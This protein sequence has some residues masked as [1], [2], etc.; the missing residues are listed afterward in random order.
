MIPLTFSIL[1]AAACAFLIYVL[2]QFRR[3]FLSAR[4]GSAGK[5][6]L[7]VANPRH[8]GF[9]FELTG[10]SCSAYGGRL[11]K[12]EVVMRKEILTGV[13][14]GVVG[15]VAPFVIVLLLSSRWGH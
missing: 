9:E 7:A 12:D 2:L 3:E 15:L 11:V 10:T 8:S 5:P 1:S 4:R 6:T 14:I 13:V